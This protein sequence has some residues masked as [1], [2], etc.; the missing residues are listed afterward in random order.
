MNGNLSACADEAGFEGA[1]ETLISGLN[2]ILKRIKAPLDEVMSVMSAISKGNLNIAIEGDY[3]GD[4]DQL[5][6][7][8]IR[9]MY[10]LIG[11]PTKSK[12]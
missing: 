9:L 7:R 1:W 5:K 12:Q 8:S 2:A 4:F 11:L 10:I 6:N 3:Q